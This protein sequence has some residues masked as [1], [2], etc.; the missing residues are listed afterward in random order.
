MQNIAAP[1][2]IQGINK[3][4]LGGLA[5]DIDREELRRV[6]ERYGDIVDTVVMID[7]D[8]K[9]SSGFGYVTF[10]DVDGHKAVEHLLQIQPVQIQGRTVEVKLASPQPL[11]DQ[12]KA[13]HELAS[14]NDD[15]IRTEQPPEQSQYRVF[16]GGLP[17]EVDKSELRLIFER[18]GVVVDSVVMID[19]ATHRSRGFGFVTFDEIDG[20]NSIERALQAQPLQVHGR[21]VEIRRGRPPTAPGEGR[22]MKRNVDP[23][24]RGNSR[25]YRPTRTNEYEDARPPSPN[26]ERRYEDDDE[27]FKRSR[28]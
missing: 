23:E 5:P 1:T 6:F 3:I 26:Y 13:H 21:S 28:Y 15:R 16:V 12:P 14:I 8:T 10:D 2:E 19:A 22:G 24:A 17:P 18:F 4:F 7:P 11:S 9:R 27:R 20:P 25:E